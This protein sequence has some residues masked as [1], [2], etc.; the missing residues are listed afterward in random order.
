MEYKELILDMLNRIVKLEK[1]VDLLKK[2]KT[3]SEEI[4]KETFIE[5]RPAQ[6]DIKATLKLLSCG[7][8]NFDGIVKEVH[9]PEECPNV[10]ERLVFDKHF[11]IGVQFKWSEE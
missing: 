3:P 6:R 7:R 5:E 11:P 8:M 9:T 10:Y 1:E 4:P 2:E